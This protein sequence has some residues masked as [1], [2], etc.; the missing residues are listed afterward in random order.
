MESTESL[1]R[2][3]IAALEREDKPS[4]VALALGAL[5][6][7]QTDIAGLYSQVLAP[8][9]NQA[10]ANDPDPETAIWKEHIRS[11]IIRT[12]LECCYP[13][14]L[15]TIERNGIRTGRGTVVLVSPAEEY[16]EI[17]ARMGADFMS[18]C[19]FS[20]LFVGSNT[21]RET[22][23]AGIRSVKPAFVVIHATSTYSLV[24]VKKI[25]L[26]LRRIDPD[27]RICGAGYAFR[28]DPGLCRELGVSLIDSIEDIQT[29]A[30]ELD[31]AA[32]QAEPAA[33]TGQ[34]RPA[35]PDAG[36]VEA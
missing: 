1:F 5:E 29:L 17:G 23:V 30:A 3:F 18:L 33:P 6:T 20:P 11:A 7:G 27:L 16:H 12:I 35:M 4:C 26:E 32:G 15:R 24:Q 21:P 13:H 28:H 36:E 22:L 31:A 10:T 14:L 8:A 34:S 9:L 25:V 19:G 2:D